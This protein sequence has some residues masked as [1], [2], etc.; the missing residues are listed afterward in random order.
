MPESEDMTMSETEA[1]RNE[2]CMI[3]Y[4]FILIFLI[5]AAIVIL[6][7][8][9]LKQSWQQSKACS[10]QGGVMIDSDYING[11]VRMMPITGK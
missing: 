11:C 4:G 2:R 6:V 10:D 5:I 9:D 8:F 7:S 3:T 1:R